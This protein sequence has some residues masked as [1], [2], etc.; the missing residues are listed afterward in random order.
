M[1]VI[2]AVMTVVVAVTA[3]IVVATGGGVGVGFFL[4]L[5]VTFMGWT[6]IL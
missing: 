1:V 3:T 5:C 4:E 2:A 6:K